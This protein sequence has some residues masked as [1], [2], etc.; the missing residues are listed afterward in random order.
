VALE[1]IGFGNWRMLISRWYSVWRNSERAG[2]AGWRDCR[3][4]IALGLEYSTV[5]G[6]GTYIEDSSSRERNT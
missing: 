2:I 5:Y 1:G 6:T 4:C 3:D